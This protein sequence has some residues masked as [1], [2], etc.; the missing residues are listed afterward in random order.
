MVLARK[1][2]LACAAAAFALSL[3]AAI[4]PSRAASLSCYERFDPTSPDRILQRGNVRR[5]DGLSQ[6]H[7]KSDAADETLVLSPDGAKPYTYKLSTE[8]PYKRIKIAN[9]KIVDAIPLTDRS[10]SLVP[11]GG[12]LGGGETNILFLDDE[13][14][15]I[16]TLKVQVAGAVHIHNKPTLSGETTYQCWASGCWYAGESKYEGPAQVFRFIN[17]DKNNNK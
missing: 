15:T 13:N 2:K 9:A 11:I 8:K 10:V 1:T 12:S 5:C 16:K 3:V 17:E 6:A 14:V 4:T 7:A